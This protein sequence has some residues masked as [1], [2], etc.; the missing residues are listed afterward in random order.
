M[1]CSEKAPLRN[2]FGLLLDTFPTQIFLAAQVKSN[3][4]LEDNQDLYRLM[5]GS[6]GSSMLSHRVAEVLAGRIEGS[7]RTGLYDPHPGLPPDVIAQAIVGSLIRLVFWWLETPNEY[8]PKQMA[9]MLWEMI[10]IEE[11]SV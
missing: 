11:L 5:L 3:L 9:D 8:T 6:Q 4:H 1:G 7:I 2:F 10:H